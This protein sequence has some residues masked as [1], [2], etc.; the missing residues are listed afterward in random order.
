L[1]D[2]AAAGEK[3]LD[4]ID[5]VQQWLAEKERNRELGGH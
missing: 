1:R 4:R 3:R 2:N 5:V